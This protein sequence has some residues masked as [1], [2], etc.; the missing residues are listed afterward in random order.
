MQ[1]R[2][3]KIYKILSKKGNATVQQLKQEVFASDATIR[4]DLKQMEQEGLLVRTWGGAVSTNNIN[5]DPPVFV[6]SKANINEKNQIAR[7]AIGFMKDNMTVFL[8]SGTTI[9]KLA[10][11]FHM[12]DNLTVITNGLDTAAALNDHLSAKVIISGGE[13]YENYDL[14]GS[15]SESTIEQFNADLF[16]FSCSGITAE[17]F[18]SSDIM[19]LNIIKKMKKNSAKTILLADTS[20][21]GKIYTYKGFGFEDIDYVVMEAAPEDKALKKALGSKLVASRAFFK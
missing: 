15:L 21:V 19:R 8:A 3:E 13:L 7:I 6:R 11:M 20:K 14:I 18:S 4:R 16:F 2:R 12:Y 9:A 17:G 1:E 5:S 10:K